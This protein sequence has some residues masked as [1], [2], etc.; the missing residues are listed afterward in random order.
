MNIGITA[1]SIAR[2]LLFLLLSVYS[3]R[4]DN[5]VPVAIQVSRRK[6]T[7][8]DVRTYS[9]T[10]SHHKLKKAQLFAH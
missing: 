8:K 2:F 7:E 9:Y 10:R 3:H 1:T 5:D 4:A 6:Q